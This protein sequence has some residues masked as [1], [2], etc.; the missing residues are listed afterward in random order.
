MD[1][2]TKSTAY[3]GECAV[4]IDGGEHAKIVDNEDGPVGG[5]GF[6]KLGI[7]DAVVR[8]EEGEDMLEMALVD[9]VGGQDELKVAGMGIEKGFDVELVRFPCASCYHDGGAGTDE[10][11]NLGIAGGFLSYLEHTVETGIASNGAL[12]NAVLLKQLERLLVLNK[13]VGKTVELTAEPFAERLEEVL[14]L[15]ED[16]GE[17]E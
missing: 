5:V 11:L 4:A 7:A 13:E 2:P 15:A 6:M 17:D 1:A 16:G 12:G 10:G 3:V 9:H 8:S 14:V